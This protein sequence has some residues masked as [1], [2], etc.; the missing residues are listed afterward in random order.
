[1]KRYIAVFHP[2]AWQHD[3]AVP[4]DPEGPTE[5][6]VTSVIGSDQ[7]P[8]LEADTYESDALR[9]TS[10]APR[11]TRDWGGPFYISVKEVDQ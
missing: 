11:W 1:M 4:V 9:E 3:Y 2:Q 5:W 6:D 7:D 10:N 8:K